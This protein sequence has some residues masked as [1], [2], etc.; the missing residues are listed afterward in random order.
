MPFIAEITV[1]D[2]PAD[3]RECGFTVDVDG[4]CRI[5]SVRVRLAPNETEKGVVSWVL[6]DLE[7]A[8]TDIDG[9][10]TKGGELADGAA[11]E[12]RNGAR[13]I[14]HVVVLT[15][16]LP[17]T[18]ASLEALGLS[19]RAT[20]DSDTYGRP[21]RQAF[22]RLGE[23]ILEVVGGQQV[24]PRGGP[25]R[26]YGLALTLDSLDDAK[27]LLGDRMG[28]PKPAVQPG[29]L[30]TTIKGLR[31]PIAVMSPEPRP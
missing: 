1:A 9:L 12:H 15:P 28:T 21:M 6:A 29:R 31:A 13:L 19:L 18:I 30:I 10:A 8:T 3:W 11:P 27:E 20:R 23:V 16:D 24:D 7:A 2:D 22:F 14:D 26:F 17:R 5:G 4:V 25:A